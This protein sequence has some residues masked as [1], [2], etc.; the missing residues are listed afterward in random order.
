MANDA[1]YDDE[2]EEAEE[3]GEAD[4]ACENECSTKLLEGR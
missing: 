4:D 3:A 2:E 1:E